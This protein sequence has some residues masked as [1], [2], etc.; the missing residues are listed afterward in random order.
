[1]YNDNGSFLHGLLDVLK[2]TVN[3][4]VWYV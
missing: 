3:F 1:L 4:T 2:L